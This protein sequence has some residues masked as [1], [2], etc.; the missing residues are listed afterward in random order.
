MIIQSIFRMTIIY[1]DLPKLKTIVYG[2]N[3]LEGKK[4]CEN[5]LIMKST[6]WSA[7]QC[8]DLPS[9][10][11]IEGKTKYIHMRMETIELESMLSKGG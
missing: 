4:D 5:K 8:V 7:I 9:L 11:S 3:A 1:V 10:T 2:D 6:D